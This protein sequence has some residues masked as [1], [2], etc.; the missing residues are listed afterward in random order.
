MPPVWTGRQS[1]KSIRHELSYFQSLDRIWR[2][3]ERVA[4]NRT[5]TLRP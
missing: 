4:F 2:E 1:S 5:H 3:L